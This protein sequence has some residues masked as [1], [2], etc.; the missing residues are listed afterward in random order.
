MLGSVVVSGR[1]AAVAPPSRRRR[2]HTHCHVA[3][4]TTSRTQQQKQ[5]PNTKTNQKK[6]D[7]EIITGLPGG[8]AADCLATYVVQGGAIKRMILMWKPRT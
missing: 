1:G 4:Q 3:L 5:T 8:A 6:V 2:T 7:R